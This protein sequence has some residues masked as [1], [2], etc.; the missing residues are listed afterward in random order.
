[1]K[2]QP[3]EPAKPV[4]QDAKPAAPAEPAAPTA[5]QPT[6]FVPSTANTHV[7]PPLPLDEPAEATVATQAEAQPAE[8]AAPQEEAASQP[9]R[10]ADV[11]F[12]VQFM[13][14]GKAL[15]QNAR[16]FKGITDYD[17]YMQ[18]GTYCYTT[19]NFRT[20]REAANYQKEVR[21]KGFKDAFVVAFAGGERIS[22]QKAKEM[23]EN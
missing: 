11:V 1:V 16:E 2:A 15:K 21:E 3:S 17:Y 10:K 18:K 14:S 5:D 12:K 22:L 13:T 23:L 19:G 20:A 9:A 4:E 8:V 6:T 7:E